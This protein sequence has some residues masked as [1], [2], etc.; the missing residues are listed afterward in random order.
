MTVY[1]LAIVA[2]AILAAGSVV[3]QRAASHA[4]P[5]KVLSFK[6]VLWLVRRPLWLSGIGLASFGNVMTAIALGMGS[7]ALIQPLQVTQLLFAL[8]L[9][10]AW[11]RRSV[12]GRDWGGAVATAAGLAIFIVAG[13]PHQGPSTT[14][15]P[16][17]WAIAGG[18]I[19]ALALALAAIG[20]RLDPIR[21]APLL[22]AGAGMLFGL[23]AALTHEAIGVFS[24]GGLVAALTN[25]QP[26]GVVVCAL[27]GIV[28][29]QSA[30][31]VAP[32]PASYPTLVVTGPLAGIAI[33]VGVQGGVL[34]LG[35]ATFAVALLGI[36]IMI[37][38]IYVLASSP[39]VTGQLDLL[40]RR[41]EEGM[42]YRTEEQLEH[43]LR[44]LHGELNQFEAH[45]DQPGW[46]SRS[47]EHLERHIERI[48]A[49]VDRLCELQ[50][51]IKRHREAERQR[52]RERAR[53]LSLRERD[54]LERH[55]R[56]LSAREREIDARARTLQ[57]WSRRLERRVEEL[58]LG[59]ER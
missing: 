15:P 22:A 34:N 53:T 49:E 42:A 11:M 3:Q 57:E 24:A 14:A 47:R 27:L 23:Q 8:P 48:E 51:D 6:L 46:A 29:I 18:T 2:S 54:E 36:A 25:W 30:Y 41:R 7:V 55:D 4:P 44:A 20:R 21:E 59:R 37:G 26:Y 19:V 39:L 32:L 58:T 33:G 16:L 31:N 12:P 13:R 28:L 45:L 10:A 9:S 35:P 56:E 50:D 17:D 5:E 40:E 1:V 43:D 38:G 52:E